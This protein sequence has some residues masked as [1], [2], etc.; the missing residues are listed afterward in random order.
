MVKALDP[1]FM[2][3]FTRSHFIEKLEEKKK[4]EYLNQSKEAEQSFKSIIEE[5][6]KSLALL[7][8]IAQSEL[9][10][11]YDAI[12][13]L[14]ASIHPQFV[15]ESRATF[16]RAFMKLDNLKQERE[17][18]I[19][20]FE[21]DGKAELQKQLQSVKTIIVNNY[22]KSGKI[23]LLPVQR[24]QMELENN[25]MEIHKIAMS[26]YRTY[27]YLKLHF[28][29][30][31]EE[32]IAATRNKLHLKL[33]L[34]IN[35]PK[36]IIPSKSLTSPKKLFNIMDEVYK[37]AH[38]EPKKIHRSLLE[39]VQHLAFMFPVARY[40]DTG[41]TN[42]NLDMYPPNVKTVLINMD[43][44]IKQSVNKYV[45]AIN[46]LIRGY[47]K[48][49]NTLDV[50]FPEMNLSNKDKLYKKLGYTEFDRILNEFIKAERMIQNQW[51]IISDEIEN[52]IK[53]TI[54]FY[55]DAS[56]VIERHALRLEHARNLI[57]DINYIISERCVDAMK[58]EEM[59]FNILTDVLRESDTKENLKN[60]YTKIVVLLDSLKES[61]MKNYS[62]QTDVT[63]EYRRIG[64]AE[65]DVFVGE[66]NVF[67][68]KH[69]R[70]S[71]IDIYKIVPKRS[72]HTFTEVDE[73][74]TTKEL[75]MC[76]NHLNGVSN[77]TLGF[78][79]EITVLKN[80]ISQSSQTEAD[81]WINKQSEIL[82]NDLQ[83]KLDNHSLRY[84]RIKK[85]ILE[86]RAAEIKIHQERLKSHTFAVETRLVELENEARSIET[87]QNDIVSKMVEKTADCKEKLDSCNESVFA[88]N[89]I[90]EIDSIQKK[91]EESFRQINEEVRIN[92]EA[93]IKWLRQSNVVFLKSVLMFSEGGNYHSEEAKLISSQMHELAN[94]IDKT[95]GRVMKKLCNQV[96]SSFANSCIDV[97]RLKDIEKKLLLE[98]E[99]ET[100]IFTLQNN[101]RQYTYEFKLEGKLLK[102]AVKNFQDKTDINNFR[103]LL[104]DLFIK[105]SERRDHLLFPEASNGLEFCSSEFP[106]I[107]SAKSDTRKGS[108]K[109]SAPKTA[110]T[111]KGVKKSK[112]E[113]YKDFTKKLF[114]LTNIDLLDPD[115]HNFLSR[116]KFSI[117]KRLR[118]LQELLKEIC[119][120]V[121][122][123][124]ED[125][126][127]AISAYE[128]RVQDYVDKLKDYNFQCEEIW[129]LE[130]TDFLHQNVILRLECND[131]IDNDVQEFEKVRLNKISCLKE[132]Y[133]DEIF[134]INNYATR[135]K[136]I[137]ETKLKPILG[138]PSNKAI[139][140]KLNDDAGKTNCESAKI[141]IDNLNLFKEALKFELDDFKQTIKYKQDFFEEILTNFFN[142]ELL[143]KLDTNLLTLS[144]VDNKVLPTEPENDNQQV[145]KEASEAEMEKKERKL[146]MK[147]L[148][149]KIQEKLLTLGAVDKDEKLISED[150]SLME[151]LMTD[152]DYELKP[153]SLQ[154][155]IHKTIE[156]FS[157][158]IFTVAEEAV[159]EQ[160][161]YLNNSKKWIRNWW[162][163]VDKVRNVFGYTLI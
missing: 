16:S 58:E 119:E 96:S 56:E 53:D 82:M 157:D 112:K 38:I 122:K 130:V 45:S 64:Q 131:F 31:G 114:H 71:I 135:E 152:A 143:K 76:C 8:K 66:M 159:A 20:E 11:N 70:N 51:K 107:D 17:I 63:K 161:K 41:A 18:L 162:S 109:K 54:I 146:R 49:L 40:S 115:K 99:L 23:G 134:H 74:I 98:K 111:N 79:E 50:K 28:K 144:A 65:S 155:L 94:L 80:N 35:C 93:Q 48:D 142:Q 85:E 46:E 67:L 147:Y 10:V 57:I 60:N 81:M 26:N 14:E 7:I 106:K 2:P 151:I 9:K 95:E 132:K 138:A 62:K 126:A 103:Q 140:D 55:V 154:S 69:P 42:T 27:V 4:E 121:A 129:L 124:T 30:I 5:N 92:C 123:K 160:E 13:E 113:I 100:T 52:S 84:K 44:C 150:I 3:N 68:K 102:D 163:N 153:I 61:F 120:I 19:E 73:K 158:Y 15:I 22:L 59:K 24:L 33:N 118:H 87:R 29:L 116:T 97:E 125:S 127:S 108:R 34:F 91:A 90:T 39:S 72:D 12:V 104:E 149:S 101:L 36:K 128:N 37:E 148:V 141:Y 25:I 105:M 47:T 77:W 43:E 86:V 136:N 83:I 21:K 156:R 75:K 137:L 78:W 110:N 6:N 32:I 139:I 145:S 89:L 1:D 117:Y 88:K 133:D